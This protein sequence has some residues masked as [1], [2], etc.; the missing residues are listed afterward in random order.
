M[1]KIVDSSK[2]LLP[3][4]EKEFYGYCLFHSLS[5][6]PHCKVEYHSDRKTDGGYDA[7]NIRNNLQSQS[8]LF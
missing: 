8:L 4:K 6:L 2:Q 7:A 5:V 1:D 3:V